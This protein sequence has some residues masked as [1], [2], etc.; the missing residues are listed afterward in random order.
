MIA[1]QAVNTLARGIFITKNSV[2]FNILSRI[3][4]A[5]SL[6][7]YFE[8]SILLILRCKTNAINANIALNPNKGRIDSFKNPRLE[9][10]ANALLQVSG[11]DRAPML[12]PGVKKA[13]TPLAIASPAAQVRIVYK[14]I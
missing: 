14:R 13:V 1:A 7:G 4:N 8:F 10:T 9:K 3:L 11:F 12:N 2:L 6:F 5:A